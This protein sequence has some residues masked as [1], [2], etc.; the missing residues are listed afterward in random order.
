M[1]INKKVFVISL[2]VIIFIGILISVFLISKPK[3]NI[4]S[5]PNTKT[6]PEIIIS[7]DRNDY[8]KG[9]TINIFVKNGL[10][11][12]ILYSNGGDRFWEIERFEDNKWVNPAYVEGGGFQLTDENIGDNCYI[13]FYEKITPSKLVSQSTIS[14]QW[15]QKICPFGNGNPNE[16]QT[17]RYID[18]GQYRLVFNYGFEIS[19]DIYRLSEIKTVYSNIFT[20]K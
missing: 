9:E 19:D 13:V 5:I 20:I 6:N 7:T 11:D 18:N 4:T 1:I 12:S 2:I 14:S 17:V 10:D 16:P 3:D 15:N 8:K